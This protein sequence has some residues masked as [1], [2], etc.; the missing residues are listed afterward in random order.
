MLV[1]GAQEEPLH[2]LHEEEEEQ[3]DP[4]AG[5]T[6]QILILKGETEAPFLLPPEFTN[7]GDGWEWRASWLIRH[8]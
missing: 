1:K 5:S 7:S 3:S 8:H 6:M 2:S 4:V